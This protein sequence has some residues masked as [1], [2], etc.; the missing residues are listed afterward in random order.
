MFEVVTIDASGDANRSYCILDRQA[1]KA[2]CV[3]PSFAARAVLD[4]ANEASCA[5]TEVFLTHTHHDHVATLSE[6]KR[7]PGVRVWAHPKEVQ[8]V[9]GC[10]PLPA[11]G[12]LAAAPGVEVIFTPGH[13][14]GGVC[15]R[16][17]QALFTGDTLFVD[18]VGRADFSGGDP[19]ALFESLA[20][21]R[22]LPGDLVIHPGHHYGCV[23]K[24]TLAEEI[25]KNKFLACTD[26]ERFLGLLPELAE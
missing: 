20:K 15:Y 7:R 26:F 18:W 6:L 25:L 9:D 21:L 23:E 24:R 1:G 3:D 19:M 5:L 22:S 14:P 16:V 8:R 13:T 4:A 2:W 10:V 11:E 12:P 17:D